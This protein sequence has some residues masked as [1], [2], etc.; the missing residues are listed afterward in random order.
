MVLLLLLKGVVTLELLLLLV[1]VR[2]VGSWYNI[3]EH[4]RSCHGVGGW[5]VVLVLLLVVMV[6][7]LH[8]RLSG[9]ADHIVREI[10]G[11]YWPL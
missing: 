11:A 4:S 6:R 2:H 1:L 7:L 3:H 9:V 8:V 5:G 10:H